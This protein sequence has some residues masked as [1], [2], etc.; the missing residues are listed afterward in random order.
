MI[1][2]I[3]PVYN[4]EDYLYVC[5]KSVLKQTYPEF[6][7]IC[8]ND[9]STD[10]SL[11]ILDYFA[12]IDDRIKIFN[13]TENRG[14]SYAR[15]IGIKHAKGDYIFF[16]DSDDWISFNTLEELS[17]NAKSND[18][19][20]VFYKLARF[21]DRKFIF[22]QPAFDLSC[23]FDKDTDFNNFTF[24]CK[25][26]KYHI[27]NTSFAPYL[28]LYKKSF[29]DKYEDFTFP[30]GL[31]YEDVLFHVKTILRASKISFIPKF[32]YVY[33]LDNQRSVMHDDSKIFDIFKIIDLVEDFLFTNNYFDELKLEFYSFKIIQ[34]LQYL[35]K[36]PN[37]KYFKLAKKKFEELNS[38]FTEDIKNE[39]SNIVFNWKDYLKVLNSNS[40]QEYQ[41]DEK[42]L[43]SS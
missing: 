41:K 23:Y 31:V 5:L 35:N 32:F 27:I 34:I 12:K 36:T 33:R 15:N 37:E 3:I 18:S 38:S 14:A 24:T 8:V 9:C 29:L 4:C 25:D 39:L 2:I 43:S 7:V 40:M 28:K 6:E 10:S 26:I 16:L 1:S 13:N 21:N 22:S 30:E 19:D 42:N 17:K 20:L 11:E